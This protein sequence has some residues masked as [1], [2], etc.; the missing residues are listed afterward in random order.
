MSH[1]A[2]SGILTFKSKAT[3]AKLVAST[4]NPTNCM[5]TIAMTAKVPATANVMKTGQAAAN[6]TKMASE[7]APDAIHHVVQVKASAA[8]PAASRSRTASPAF[9]ANPTSPSRS[10]GSCVCAGRAPAGSRRAGPPARG[11]PPTVAHRASPPCKA[12]CHRSALLLRSR[13]QAGCLSRLRT[14]EQHRLL[15]RASR[16]SNPPEHLRRA[17]HRIARGCAISPWKPL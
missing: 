2:A 17:E 10:L 1:A 15:C 6:P 9:S 14:K 3:I 7:T 5:P 12:A 4:E 16:P 13:L 8:G 11:L